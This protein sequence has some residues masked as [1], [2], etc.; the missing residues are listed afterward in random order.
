MKKISGMPR[1]LPRMFF[2]CILCGVIFL[3]GSGKGG[4]GGKGGGQPSCSNSTIKTSLSILLPFGNELPNYNCGFP[5]SGSNPF[6]DFGSNSVYDASKYYLEIVVRGNCQNYERTYIWN[7]PQGFME[8]EVPSGGPYTVIVDYYAACQDVSCVPS[9]PQRVRLA[10][11][12]AYPSGSS[13]SIA[14]L[15]FLRYAPCR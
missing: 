7:K 2:V 10:S 13:A 9:P 12:D 4:G 14:K 11:K 15:K 1:Y 8:I 3:G 6:V 5:A